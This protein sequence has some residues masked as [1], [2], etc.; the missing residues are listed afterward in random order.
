M[1]KSKILLFA[2]VTFT[3]C[4]C[5]KSAGIGG[6]STIKG[7]VVVDNINILG[8]I[9]DSYDAQDLDVYIIYGKENSTWF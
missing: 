1:K 8:N 4:T 2:I 3:F 5:T 9:V 7:K 6:T